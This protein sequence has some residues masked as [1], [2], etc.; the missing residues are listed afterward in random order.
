MELLI[1]L[2]QMA[3]S[4]ELKAK[5][6]KEFGAPVEEE[7]LNKLISESAWK[8]IESFNVVHK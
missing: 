5:L 2:V 1:F 8:D 6:E 3:Q 4:P 7:R